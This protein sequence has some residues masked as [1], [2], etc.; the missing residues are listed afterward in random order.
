[1]TPRRVPQPLAC[2]TEVAQ[3]DHPLESYPFERTY[4]R[5]TGDA[6]DAPGA[7]AFSAAAAHA[8]AS[9]A[10]RYHEI[11]SNHM[12]PSNRPAELTELLLGCL[13]VP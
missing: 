10:W 3:L 4:I 13:Q 5:A 9:D 1:M 8:K 12:V 7:A 11:A 2:F 6:P